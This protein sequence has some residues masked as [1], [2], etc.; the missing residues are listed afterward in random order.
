[1]V[2]CVS[3]I[4]PVRVIPLAVESEHVPVI[5]QKLLECVL[6]LVRTKRLHGSCGLQNSNEYIIATRAM[7]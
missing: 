4:V 7:E 1:M 5:L 2:C 3:N 6:F